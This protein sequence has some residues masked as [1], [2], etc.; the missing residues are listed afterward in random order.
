MR[1]ICIGLVLLFAAA[2]GCAGLDSGGYFEDYNG[3]PF[4]WLLTKAPPKSRTD[5]LIQKPQFAPS[6]RFARQPAGSTDTSQQAP[7]EQ[8]AAE[9]SPPAE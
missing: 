8:A 5:A 9:E 4:P 1:R 3:F 7:S 6:G 2:S